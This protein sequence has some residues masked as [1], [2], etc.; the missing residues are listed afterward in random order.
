VKK[1]PERVRQ[2]GF[3]ISDLRKTGAAAGEITIFSLMIL[4][5]IVT[6]IIKEAAMEPDG[7]L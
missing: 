5:K 2:K 3:T 7:E 4:Y 6:F 1:N